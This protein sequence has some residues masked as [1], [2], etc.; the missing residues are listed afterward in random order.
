MVP[1]R[2]GIIGAN[3]DR[4]WAVRAHIP[5]LRTLPQF[6]LMAVGTS[7]PDSARR[8]GELFQARAFTDPRRL[9]EDPEV[10]LVVITVKAQAHAELIRTALAAGKH[11]YCEWPLASATAEAES[12]TRQAVAAGVRH[13]IGLQAGY[14]PA[15]RR[16]RQLLTEGYVGQVLSATV[17]SARGKGAGGRVPAWAAYTLDQAQGAGLLEVAGGHTL[18]AVQYL[19]GELTEVS[20]QLAVR[21]RRMVVA[22]TGAALEVSS[23]DHLLLNATA[24]DGIPVAAHIHDAKVT[25]GRTRIE[26]AGTEG[27]LAIVS[28]AGGP[29]GIQMSELRLLGSRGTGAGFEQLPIEN[30]SESASFGSEP[31]NVLH[32]YAALHDDIR[33]GAHTVPDFADGVRIHRLL[34]AIRRSDETGTRISVQ[35]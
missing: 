32:Q 4:G 17:Y 31:A 8:A 22:D 24:A 23:P 18:H 26:I 25:D 29:G 27:D 16:A 6:H 35:Q 14:A 20:A 2:V 3:P 15:I 30:H 34:D 33:T 9:A 11:V 5:A 21:N 19:I 7:R 10:D 28:G 12:L 1:I 13:V